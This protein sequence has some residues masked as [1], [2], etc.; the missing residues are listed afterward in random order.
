MIGKSK[1]VAYFAAMAI[2]ALLATPGWAQEPTLAGVWKQIDPRT[3]IVGGLILFRENNGLWEGYIVKMYPK[4]GDPENP[5]CTA[6]TGDRKNQP[7]LGLRLV[8]NAKRD[9]LSYEN[10]TILDPRNGSEYG[11]RVT[12]SPDNQT[13]T[14][15][16]FLGIPLLGQ[17][18]EWKRL[19]EDERRKLQPELE[20]V[21][22]GPSND[23]AKPTR[24][25]LID[26]KGALAK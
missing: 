15:R 5:T 6:C 3:G 7:L 10:G 14:V 22:V 24:K 2:S 20:R 12:L 25:K 13:V 19:S 9:G 4:P 8:E 21:K 11:V 1:P 23:Q 18:Q 26:G 17:S 16:G